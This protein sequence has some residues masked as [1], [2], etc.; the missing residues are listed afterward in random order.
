MIFSGEAFTGGDVLLMELEIKVKVRAGDEVFFKGECIA[1]KREAVQGV[2][3]VGRQ[4]HP[5]EGANWYDK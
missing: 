2:M 5:Q 1:Y 4:L 3:E